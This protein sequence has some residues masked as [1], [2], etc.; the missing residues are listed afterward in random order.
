MF[1]KNLLVVPRAEPSRW[2]LTGLSHLFASHFSPVERA[3][4]G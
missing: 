1:L 3:L 4:Q 2:F